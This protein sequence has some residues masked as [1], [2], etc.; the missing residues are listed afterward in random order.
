MHL[1]VQE[2]LN[3]QPVVNAS[4]ALPTYLSAQPGDLNGLTN[5]LACLETAYNNGG[6]FVPAYLNA[7][8]EGLDHSLHAL[9]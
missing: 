3:K 4:N 2:H 5:T 1:S 6:F 8:F 7:G 9:G